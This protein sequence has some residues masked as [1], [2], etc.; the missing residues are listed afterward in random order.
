MLALAVPDALEDADEDWDGL[1]LELGL[2]D[3]NGALLSLG[4]L[5]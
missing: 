2:L 4:P 1:L 3:C 5:E